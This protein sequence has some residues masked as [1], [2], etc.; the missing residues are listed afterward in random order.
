MESDGLLEGE[1]RMKGAVG[2]GV[3]NR[4]VFH[5]VVEVEAIRP[6][7]GVEVANRRSV[8]E[9][10]VDSSVEGDVVA[11]KRT[12]HVDD[13][14]GRGLAGGARSLGV[15]SLSSSFERPAAG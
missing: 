1:A 15:C 3:G 8:A 4:P 6:L 7:D 12:A 2:G 11:E 13:A 9:R 5:L 10:E 14:V